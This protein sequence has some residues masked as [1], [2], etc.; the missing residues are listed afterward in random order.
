MGYRSK[1]SENIEEAQN[2]F[3]LDFYGNAIKNKIP[4]FLTSGTL[5]GAFRDKKFLTNDS[6]HDFGLKIVDLPSELLNPV[7]LFTLL[8][9]NKYSIGSIMKT[10]FD[11]L[12]SKIPLKLSICGTLQFYEP[13]ESYEDPL[14]IIENYN[15]RHNYLIVDNYYI[16]GDVEIYLPYFHDNKVYWALNNFVQYLWP[17]DDL[18]DTEY[19][20]VSGNTYLIPKN[21]ENYLNTHYSQWLDRGSKYILH[22]K[23]KLPKSWYKRYNYIKTTSEYWEWSQDNINYKYFFKT[24]I[25]IQD[26]EPLFI[27]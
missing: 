5:I 21:P 15:S 3:L 13:C 8:S 26:K 7:N 12:D 22:N 11:G 2:N 6:D 24:K 4:M 19:I 17:I 18:M 23:T 27:G 9:N 20:S 10:N 25:I 14:D 1:N 16:Y